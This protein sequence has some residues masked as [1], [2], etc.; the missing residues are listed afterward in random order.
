MAETKKFAWHGTWWTGAP[1]NRD[2]RDAGNLHITCYAGQSLVAGQRQGCESQ[3]RANSPK[4]SLPINASS[5]LL[6]G[7]LGE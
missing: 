2:I 1:R 6:Q 5:G 4:A 7:R 3:R